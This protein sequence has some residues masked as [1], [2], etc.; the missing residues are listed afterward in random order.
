M[1]IS[2]QK[3]S[4]IRAHFAAAGIARPQRQFIGYEAEVKRR[5]IGNLG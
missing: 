3:G 4:V 2:W 1:G 5:Q